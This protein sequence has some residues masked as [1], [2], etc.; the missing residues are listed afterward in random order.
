MTRETTR[1]EQAL[2]V[3]RMRPVFVWATGS[4][5]SLALGRDDSRFF[6]HLPRRLA[7]SVFISPRADFRELYYYEEE[8]G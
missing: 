2:V 8:A 3:T 6:W 4:L 5:H 7:A 1:T